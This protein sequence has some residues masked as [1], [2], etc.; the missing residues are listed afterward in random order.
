MGYWQ[1]KTQYT[2]DIMEQNYRAANDSINVITLRN[3][4]LLYEKDAYILKESELMDQINITKDE[5]KELKNKLKSSIDY[6]TKIEGSLRIDTIYTNDTIYITKDTTYIHFDYNDLWLSLNGTTK[7]YD[8]KSQTIINKLTV[9]ISIQ[10]GLTEDYNI[11]I[12]TDNPYINIVEL[13]GA[14]IRNNKFN[15]KFKH[16]LQVGIGF[17]YGLFNQRLD[18]GP[19]VGYGFILEF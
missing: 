12:K 11:F 4:E 16:E 10:T 18:F 2:L 8:N 14:V 7:L 3:N 15:P 6:I 5:I 13:D 19:Q 9:P 1:S 17:Q